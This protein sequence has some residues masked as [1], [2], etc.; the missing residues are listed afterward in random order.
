MKH[1]I[2]PHIRIRMALIMLCFAP[3]LLVAEPSELSRTELARIDSCTGEAKLKAYADACT[4]FVLHN[5]IKEEIILIRAYQN[6]AIQQRHIAH[7]TQA[8]TLRLY[9]FYNNSLADS[10]LAYMPDDLFFMHKHAQ[11][12]SYYSCRSLLV[13]RLQH[14]KRLQSAL[15]EAKAM[16]NDALK[17][18]V[19]YGIGISAYLIASCY[20]S[21]T[22]HTEA[23]DFFFK[24]EQPFRDENSSGQLHNLYGIAWK[25]L[26]V[27][28]RY[29]EV[30][31]LTTRW[32]AMWRTYCKSNSLELNA[33]APYYTVCLLAKAHVYTKTDALTDA[34][35]MLDSAQVYAHGQRDITHLLLLKEEALY[36]E[37]VANYPRALEH[38]NE[39]HRIQMKLNN[40]LGAIETEEMRARICCKSG[41]Y[42]EAAKIYE[43]ILVN[44]DSITNLNLAAQLD[45][46]SSIYKVNDLTEQKETVELWRNIAFAI[47]IVLALII[48]SHLYYRHQLRIKNIAIVQHMEL[49]VEAKH[50]LAVIKSV[51]MEEQSPNAILFDQI[52]ELLQNP[53][54]IA[55]PSLDR[56]V[57][58]QIVGSNANYV[59]NAIKQHTNMKVLEYINK[60][61]IEHACQV[62]KQEEKFSFQVIWVSCGFSSRSTFYRIFNEHT[63][64]SPKSYREVVSRK[65]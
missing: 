39:Y 57:L 58:A 25:S 48:A 60:V 53:E 12:L 55:N 13:E 21:M 23:V 51:A 15:R 40:R 5:N 47:C 35:T 31:Q 38:L 18:E 61:R 32:E 33:V 4:Q 52:N 20:Q 29:D 14:D 7:E 42:R 56:E 24:A 6:E 34:R 28:H 2:A 62:L 16:Y 8:R 22:R 36:E 9:A 64:M 63:G 3:L 46:L 11:W 26:A 37:A 17:Q 43:V 54:I 59:A 27:L 49:Q 1:S 50:Q 19:D 41:N 65:G 10:L 30:L 45:D 44:K